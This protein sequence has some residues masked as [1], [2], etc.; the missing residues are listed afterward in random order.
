MAT[1]CLRH[2]FP[3]DCFELFFVHSGEVKR[4]EHIFL[5]YVGVLF[6]YLDLVAKA[7]INNH[8]AEER[9][10]IDQTLGDAQFFHNLL[11]FL[12]FQ[13]TFD[14][15]QNDVKEWVQQIQ[16]WVLLNMLLL[17]FMGQVLLQVQKSI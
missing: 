17:D 10:R 6:E 12:N 4:C 3:K 13:Y 7:V 15:V 16:L 14:V 5:K 2:G 8:H 9:R 11:L 1:V